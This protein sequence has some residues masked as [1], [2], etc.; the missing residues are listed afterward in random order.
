MQLIIESSGAYVAFER[1]DL[2][3]MLF[4]ILIP[5]RLLIPLG[6]KQ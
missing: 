6:G 4:R 2:H 3:L 5:D 1:L